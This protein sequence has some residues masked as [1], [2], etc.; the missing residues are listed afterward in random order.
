MTYAELRERTG[1]AAAALVYRG[2]SCGRPVAVRQM[3]S[4]DSVVASLACIWIGAVAAPARAETHNPVLLVAAAVRSRPPVCVVSLSDLL[5]TRV[6]GVA[7]ALAA[8]VPPGFT[9]LL[10]VLAAGETLRLPSASGPGRAHPYDV[11]LACEGPHRVPSAA[12]D[13]YDRLV[14]A[15][16]AL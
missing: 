2:V 14:G 13:A 8:E 10:V 12:I 9:T 3:P 1:R 15:T 4:V 7:P 16:S 5:R 11:D 6:T